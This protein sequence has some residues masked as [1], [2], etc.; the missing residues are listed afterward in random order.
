M[1]VLDGKIPDET[2]VIA[3][4]LLPLILILVLGVVYYLMFGL[5]NT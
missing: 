1:G 5:L 4:V 2:L 3:V